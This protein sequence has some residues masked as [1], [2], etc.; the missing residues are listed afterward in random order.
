MKMYG[1]IGFPLAHSFSKKYFTEKFEKEGITDTVFY[2]FPLT[3]IIEFP[4]LLKTNSTLKGLNVTIP[5]KEQVLKYVTILS[6]E[7]IQIGAANCIKIRD[8]EL[9]AYNTDVI[10]FEKSFVKKLSAENSKALILGSGGSSKAVQYVLKKLGIDFL[11]VSRIMDNKE[12]LIEYKHISKEILNDFTVI[13]N[14]T[15]LGMLP[16]ES[17]FPD[18]PYSLLTSKHYLFDLVYNPAKTQFLKKGEV[19]GATIEN[20]YEMLIL[21]AEESWKIWNEDQF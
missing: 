14:C 10:G 2:N 1:L 21:Q 15:P 7:V 20:G 6:E 17:S 18:I 8:N 5:Y 13:I 4:Q 9:K 3:S 16:D 12:G 19:Q 11:I